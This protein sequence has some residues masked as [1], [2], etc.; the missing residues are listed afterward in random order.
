[1]YFL[2]SA[3]YGQPSRTLLLSMPYFFQIHFHLYKLFHPLICR[4]VTQERDNLTYNHKSIPQFPV[5]S[6]LS[7][8]LPHNP[9]AF[10]QS[11]V[12]SG[13]GL[14][15]NLPQRSTGCSSYTL[16]RTYFS[17]SLYHILL[18]G[19]QTEISASFLL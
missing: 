14:Y 1:M 16:P 13:A 12:P 4:C 5:Y 3:A 11:H 9:P 18:Q 10:L 6:F 19:S 8:G 2:L 7:G 15:Q 17:G